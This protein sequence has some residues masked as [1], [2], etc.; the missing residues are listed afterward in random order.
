LQ[1]ATIG[2]DFHQGRAGW[3]TGR[4]DKTAS[5]SRPRF[6]RL[7]AG[8][9]FCRDSGLE[10][11]TSRPC[12]FPCKGRWSPGEDRKRWVRS[13][14]AKRNPRSSMASVCEIPTCCWYQRPSAFGSLR[15]KKNP[16]IPVTFSISFPRAIASRTA[17]SAGGGGESFG[18][19]AVCPLYQLG[20]QDEAR[21][22]TECEAVG[23]L[24]KT[25]HPPSE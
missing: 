17:A 8:L 24:E 2:S 25:S 18:C 1:V 22:M 15:R 23:V 16:P 21:Q 11:S 12:R 4:W 19:T 9:P 5:Q 7:V 14:A 3:R 6:Q 10:S 13:L 20:S